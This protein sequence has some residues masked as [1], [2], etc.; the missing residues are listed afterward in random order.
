M[1][2]NL[3]SAAIA[4]AALLAMSGLAHADYVPAGTLTIQSSFNPQ[5]S[6]T[7]D[8]IQLSG[9]LGQHKFNFFGGTGQFST[10]DTGLSDS[11]GNALASAILTFDPT[12]GNVVIYSGAASIDQLFV[13][14]DS[15]RGETYDFDLNSSITTL[16]DQTT[17]SGT[18][19][20]LYLLGYLT[21]S[22][23]PPYN[24]PT[25][26]ALTLSL[27]QTGTSNWSISGTLSNPPPGTGLPVPEPTSMLLLGG[28]LAALGLVRRRRGSKQ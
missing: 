19:I 20:G 7:N 1:F 3:K 21:A 12:V 2:K 28:G 14:T 26:T 27:T 24:T 10:A 15:T 11:P 13:F 8:T 17:G 16:S 5:V 22:G 6:L 18:T 9:P 4:G 23:V 25:P